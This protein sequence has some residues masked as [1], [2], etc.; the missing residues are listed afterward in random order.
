MPYS[1]PTL[2]DISQA[3]LQ[4]VQAAKLPGVDGLLPFAV[5]RVLCWALAG[6][7]YEHYGYQDWIALQ[8]VPFTAQDEYLTGWAGLKGITQK[9]ATSAVL[10]ATFTGTGTTTIPAGTAMS[11]LDGAVF[12]TT[13]AASVSNGTVTV[14]VIAAVAGSAGNYT[15]QTQITLQGAIAGINASGTVA[16]LVTAGAD[17]ETQD[18]FRTRMLAAYANPPQGGAASDYVEWAEAVAGVTR[19]WVNPNGYGAGSVVVY[20]MFD[21]A[22]AAYNHGFPIGTDGSATSETRYPHATGDQL[23]V[24]NVLFSERPATALVIVCSPVATPVNVSILCASA[25]S[26]AQQQAVAGALQDLFVRIGSPLGTAIY[27]SDLVTAITSVSGV[28]SFSITVP[29]SDFVVPIGGLPTLGTVNY[30]V[31]P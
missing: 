16:S 11:T 13:A 22:E 21:A 2:T 17:E 4:D 27:P 18:A 25:F 24:A 14:N 9:P 31:G 12:K 28:P 19:A 15:S 1:R 10:Q 6:L 20:V 5:L 8:A 26:S 3:A 7:A 30:T 29:A 23:T